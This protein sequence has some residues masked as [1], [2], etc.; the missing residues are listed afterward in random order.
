MSWLRRHLARTRNEGEAVLVRIRITMAKIPP[1]GYTC[2]IL[3]MGR[4]RR[5]PKMQS[6]ENTQKVDEHVPEIDHPLWTASKK[7]LC[8]QPFTRWV[9]KYYFA[10]TEI[11]METKAEC[12][13]SNYLFTTIPYT[14]VLAWH[15]G[16]CPSKYLLWHCPNIL[17]K[18]LQINLI[19]T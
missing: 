10:L 17:F 18:T 2:L 11:A 1:K 12:N 15:P 8:P 9:L 5:N 3:R 14:S 4:W 6:K 13:S 16:I 19:K 7:S